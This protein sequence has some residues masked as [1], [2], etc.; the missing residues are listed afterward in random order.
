MALDLIL[1]G[2]TGFTGRLVAEYLR[3][4]PLQWAI[5]GRDENKLRALK[6]ELALD[7]PI[8]VADAKDPQSIVKQTR[9]VCTTVGPYAKYGSPLVAACAANGVD[10]CDLAGETQWIRR[11]I[12]AHH[13]DAKKSGAR[14]VPCCGFDSIPSDLGTL[15]LQEHARENF[16]APCDAIT[17]ALGKMRGGFSGGTVAS[18]LNI[19]DELK[20][21]PS[22]R[23]VLFDP[24]GLNPEGERKG[25]D[26]AD[27]RGV[28]F[29]RELSA[30]TAPFMMAA[31]NT[32]V[33]RRSNALSGY[34][35]G[36]DF[37]YREVMAFP[38]GPRGLA[39]ATGVTAGLGSFMAGMAIPPVRKVMQRFV[40]APGEGPSPR[41]RERGFFEVD[42]VGHG[43]D[44][45]V[46][47]RV[48]GR[49]DPGYAATAVMLAESALSLAK[50]PRS[51]DGGL[52]TPAHAM[53]R[54]LIDRLIAAGMTFDVEGKR[55]TRAA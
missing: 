37:R 10:Y 27:Q 30:W 6:S 48:R 25:P 8:L 41:E 32:R 2:A 31:I 4:K 38:R 9:V 23:K 53:G 34:R 33:V 3:G 14:I 21:D 7:V 26:G 45:E 35:Y 39:M 28:A 29:D 51:S 17:F 55:T 44:F 40:P 1:F 54:R 18:L 13:D 50:D 43:R 11:M 5:A 20:R 42:L 46:R 16:G 15:M 19:V 24:Y 12:D 47:G 36:R 49:G 22:V 52:L